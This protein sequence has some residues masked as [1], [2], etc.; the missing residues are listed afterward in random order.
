MAFVIPIGYA[1]L[2]LL[3]VLTVGGTTAAVIVKKVKDT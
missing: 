2:G 3:G 1:I